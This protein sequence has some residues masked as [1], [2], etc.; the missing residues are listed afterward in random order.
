[1]KRNQ[2]VECTRGQILLASTN[3]Y[4]LAMSNGITARS[5]GPLARMRSPRPVNA[6]VGL[7]FH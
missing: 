3:P 1:M 5:T 7:T 2:L 4:L 6:I